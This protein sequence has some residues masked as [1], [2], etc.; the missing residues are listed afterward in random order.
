M[1]GHGKQ[2]A[3]HVSIIP[4]DKKDMAVRL[5]LFLIVV[6]ATVWLVAGRLSRPDAS[7]ARD[8]NS[9]SARAEGDY[10]GSSSCR[11]CHEEFYELWAPSHHG[12]AM[13]PYTRELAAT[14]LTAHS[15][16][17]R[18]GQYTY[19]AC[20]DANEGYM[21]EK[22]PDAERKLPIAHAMGGRNIYYF[23]TPTHKGR[24]QTMPLA[25]DVNRR[26]WYDTAES[27]VRHFP[28]GLPDEP[29]HWT[30]SMYTFN[31]S[32]YDCHVSQL[33]T[34]YDP[35]TDSYNT[36][37]AEPGINCETCH[38]PAQ[39][40]VKVCR[41]APEG[42][43]PDDIRIIVTGDFTVEQTNSMCGSCH[44]KMNPVSSSFPPGGRYYDHFGLTI[45]D[46]LDFYPDGRDL[47]ENYTFTT[48]SMSPCVKSGKLDCMHCHTSSGR[49]RFAEESRANEA[50]MPC[51]E[52]RVNNSAEH[53]HHEAGTEGDRCVTCHMPTTEFARMTRSDHS[54]RP[55]T[56]ATTIKYKSPNAC[57]LCHDEQDAEW[58]DQYVRRWHADDYQKPVL[59]LAALI[60]EARRSDWKRLDE[61]LA[62]IGRSDR[63][64]VFAGSLIRLLRNCESPKKW[65]VIIEALEND[66]SPLVRASAAQALDS[67]VAPEA[68]RALLEATRDEYRLVRVDA[69]ASLA[70]IS[71]EQLQ[72]PYNQTLKAATAEYIDAMHSRQDDYVSH[73]NLGN[74]YM[75]RQNGQAARKAFETAIRLRPDFVPPYVNVAFVY[76]ALGQNSKAEAAFNTA[77]ELEPKNLP[78]YLNLGMLLGEMDR[79]NDAER[80]F[81]KALEV[82]PNSATAAY[83]LGV[84]IAS[85]KPDES[86]KWCRRASELQ[87]DNPRY[88]YTYAFYLVQQGRTQQGLA[89]LEAM[90]DRKAAS[91]EAYMLLGATLEKQGKPADA[92]AVYRRG[93]QNEHLSQRDR[94]ILALKLQQLSE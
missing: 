93:R 51:H 2:Y 5:F 37:W 27:A 6:I 82:D 63:D 66:P 71:P 10:I 50:C 92:A 4:I 74:F 32:C 88:A 90:I 56:P 15:G 40:H 59:E 31:T 65:P 41:E 38:G 22:G 28:G 33:S 49:Y 58:S 78:A 53:T 55:P 45:L 24:L 30:D 77:I 12:L 26:Q 48:W 57:N 39:E 62:Y 87:P 73:Y 13:Q 70:S 84:L 23:L 42:Q 18:I 21:L 91:L 9:A 60:D 81:R 68:A 25:Y 20:V 80:T 34:N 72:P 94:Q 17:I 3:D 83:N 76:N 52:E 75:A 67:P 69:A 11:E 86:L 16:Q 29:I 1:C 8:A 44:A 64:A 36:T 47:G 14:K 89:I 79:P 7:A 46:H 54:M 43:V 61:M 35:A 85:D 19:S